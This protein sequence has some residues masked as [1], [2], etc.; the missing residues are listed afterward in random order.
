MFLF[1]Y[2]ILEWPNWNPSMPMPN[3][4][5]CI[6]GHPED[7]KMVWKILTNQLGVKVNYNVGGK[8]PYPYKPQG[9]DYDY[10]YFAL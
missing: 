6:H 8:L 10:F 7:I 1:V 9:N 4:H 2:L 5:G 3:S